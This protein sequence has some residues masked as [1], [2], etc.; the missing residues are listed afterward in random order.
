LLSIAGEWRLREA[1]MTKLITRELAE[2]LNGIIF[3]VEHR[4]YGKSQ[5]THD[6]TEDSLQYLT[7]DQAIQDLVHFRNEIGQEFHLNDAKWIA[8]GGSYPAL[9]AARLRIDYPD[10]FYGAHASSGP[11]FMVINLK[12]YFENVA[13]AIKKYAKS[14]DVCVTEISKASKLIETL[15]ETP[16]GL[17]FLQQNFNTCSIFTDPK[18]IAGNWRCQSPW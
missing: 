1:E 14:G 12:S 3:G 17:E 5:P 11:V 16:K 8:F 18:D 6:W 10:L 15:A 9:I 7:L 13:G 4:F 2:N